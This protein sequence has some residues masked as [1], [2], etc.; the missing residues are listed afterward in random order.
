[1]KCLY[2]MVTEYIS[3]YLV[4]RNTDGIYTLFI[5]VQSNST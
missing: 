4:S 1:M 5:Y 3:T 2:E